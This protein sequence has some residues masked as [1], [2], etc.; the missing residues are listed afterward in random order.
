MNSLNRCS[1]WLG[2]AGILLAAVSFLA[3]FVGATW[4][5]SSKP[6]PIPKSIEEGK[7]IFRFDT[8]G[9]EQLWTDTLQLHQVIE[10]SVDPITATSVGL[11]IDVDALPDSILV[12]LLDGSLSL[13]SPA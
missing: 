7:E 13:G 5:H 11:K 2:R 6:G 10:D 3:L 12:G 8:F 9:D 4:F 1:R